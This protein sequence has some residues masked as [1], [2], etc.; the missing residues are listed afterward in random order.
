MNFERAARPVI[1]VV[2]DEPDKLRSSL[3]LA[4]EN[5]ARVTVRHPSDIE[6]NDLEQ[7]HLIL[8]DYRLDLWPE[9]DTQ[10]TAFYVRT[11]MALATILREATDEIKP[12]RFTAVA[13]YTAHLHEAS[14]RIRPPI[15]RHVVARLNNLEWVFEKTDEKRFDQIVLM[16]RAAQHLDSYWPADSDASEARARELLNIDAEVEWFARSWREVRECQPPIYQLATSAGGHRVTGSSHGAFFFRW[17]LQHIFPYPCFLWDVNWVAARLRIQVNDLERLIASDCILAR[18]LDQLRYTGLLAEFLGPRWWRTAIEDYVWKVG[19]QSSGH[20]GEFEDRLR[21]K[22]GEHL[23]MVV[24]RDPVVCLDK[25][26]Q[27][28]GVASPQDAIRLRPD[29]WPPFADAAWM[30]IE[31]VREDHELSAMVDPL[32]QY[33]VD[34]DE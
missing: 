22:A 10:P 30:R 9:R 27:P 19:G 16:A 31:T 25:D 7:A 33:R 18:D 6:D 24:P 1:L 5:Q 12:D 4:W 17:L 15:S 14:G 11:G 13:L 23:E 2:D 3:K 26:F 21:E 28:N 29:Y 20:F 8:M 32:D 34:A